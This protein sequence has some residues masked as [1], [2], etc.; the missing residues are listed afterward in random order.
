[1]HAGVDTWFGRNEAELHTVDA[2]LTETAW[3]LTPAMRAAFADLVATG[4]VQVHHPDAVGF[5]R[6]AALL[7][8]YGDLNPDWADVC[9]VWLAE[10]TG[11]QRIATLD[12]RDFSTYRIHGRKKFVLESLQ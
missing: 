3:F 2:V 11:I 10:H 6:M 4:T 8:K 1:M 7:R 5:R 12:V 9:L